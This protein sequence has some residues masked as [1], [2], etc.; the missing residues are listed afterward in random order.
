M[1]WSKAFENPTWSLLLVALAAL[2]Q[3]PCKGQQLRTNAAGEQIIVYP[4]GKAVYFNDRSPMKSEGEDG[5]G[6]YPVLAVDIEPLGETLTPTELDLRRIA[7]RRLNLAREALTLAGTRVSAAVNNRNGLRAKFNVAKANGNLTE[8]SQLRKRFELATA[9]VEE[10]TAVE[11]DAAAKVA[12][13]ETVLATGRYVETYN[14][15]QRR[16]Q[17]TLS[18]V[19]VPTGQERKLSLLLPK[20]PT[21][22]GYGP[23]GTPAGVSEPL[24]CSGRTTVNVASNGASPLTPLLPFFS[25]TAPSLRPFLEGQEYLTANAYT[26]R[27]QGGQSYLHLNLSFSQPTARTAY[28]TL[29]AGASMSIHFL[30]GRSINLAGERTSVGILNHRRGSLEYDVDY[31]LSRP[32]LQALERG[33]IDFVRIYWSGGYEEYP[34]FRVDRLRRLVGCL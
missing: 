7:E 14:A 33:A 22:S 34:V 30:N 11:E 21:F 27:A 28:G 19:D 9:L 4:D 16:R 24:P 10:S 12:D 23:T 18:D 25:Y 15:E 13:I 8:M 32:Q 6:A 17:G 20:P 29:P 2:T 5:E 26:A 31:P 3:V 1:H